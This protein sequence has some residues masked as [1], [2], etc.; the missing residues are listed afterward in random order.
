MDSAIAELVRRTQFDEDD[1]LTFRPVFQRPIKTEDKYRQGYNLAFDV[2]IGA[3]R[4]Q[5]IS[6]DLVSDQVPLGSFDVVWPDDLL[7]VSGLEY[8]SYKVYSATKAIADKLC[9]I[10][11]KHDGRPS[12]RVKDLVDLCVYAKNSTLCAKEL[13][14]AVKRECAAR[15]IAVPSEFCVPLE[16][17][18]AYSKK[19]AKEVAQSGVSDDAQTLEKAVVL[20]K[21]LLDPILSKEYLEDAVWSPKDQSWFIHNKA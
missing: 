9:G 13:R 5:R 8:H 19:F 2:Y 20:I 16:W 6:V 14:R 11:E 1:Y 18:E 10:I 12:S 17:E 4:V 3:K 21:H 7:E 15:S